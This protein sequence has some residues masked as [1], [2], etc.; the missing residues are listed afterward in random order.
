VVATMPVSIL[1]WSAVLFRPH[2]P[3]NASRTGPIARRTTPGTAER[4]DA[5]GGRSLPRVLQIRQLVVTL[6]TED[7]PIS[8]RSRILNAAER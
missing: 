8:Y 3:A 2:A 7:R 5:F 1:S 6:V 4:C